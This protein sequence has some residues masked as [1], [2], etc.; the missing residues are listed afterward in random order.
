MLSLG[1]GWPLSTLFV[2]KMYPIVPR[3]QGMYSMLENAFD[4]FECVSVVY[5]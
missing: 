2:G 4:V 5:V 1:D 3:M